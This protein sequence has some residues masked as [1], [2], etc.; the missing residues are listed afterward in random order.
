LSRTQPTS[1]VAPFASIRSSQTEPRPKRK[2]RTDDIPVT[3]PPPQFSQ[4]HSL[5]SHSFLDPKFTEQQGR[6][7]NEFLVL[8]SRPP[9]SSPS[10]PPLRPPLPSG[11]LVP[12]LPAPL[13]QGRSCRALPRRHIG[14]QC[15]PWPCCVRRHRP[16]G[17]M[18][19]GWVYP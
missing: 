8:P 3:P 16:L 14:R 4:I 10:G 1:Q 17:R 9:V 19:C 13:S 15:W 12:S 2:S 6:R 7:V 18:H 11:P 5:P